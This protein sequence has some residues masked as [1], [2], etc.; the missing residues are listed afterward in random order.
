MNSKISLYITFV[1]TLTHFVLIFP[2]WQLCRAWRTE[3]PRAAPRASPRRPPRHGDR[4]RRRRPRG[5]LGLFQILVT[6]VDLLSL[7]HGSSGILPLA[8]E[9]V[10]L[11]GHRLHRGEGEHGS[12]AGRALHCMDNLS[13][14]LCLGL[15]L[16]RPRWRVS[17]RPWTPPS[18]TPTR[19]SST[20]CTWT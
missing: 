2:A 14:T 17:A 11:R 5:D 18:P 4:A 15:F 10:S 3:E 19:W 6:L 1:V 12:P 20:T 9:E 8:D 7:R 13:L 16:S